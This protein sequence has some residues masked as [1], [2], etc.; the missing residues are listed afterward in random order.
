MALQGSLLGVL[1]CRTRH[2]I[3]S[4]QTHRCHPALRNPRETGQQSAGKL[5]D[6]RTRR[7]QPHGSECQWQSPMGNDLR[8]AGG[9]AGNRPEGAA[10][11]R[12]DLRAG[13]V[14]AHGPEDQ[15]DAAKA[16]DFPRSVGAARPQVGENAAACLLDVAHVWARKH[17]VQH[18]PNSTTAHHRGTKPHVA[19]RR[20]RPQDPE[21]EDLR[22]RQAPVHFQELQG[23]P[24]RLARLRGSWVRGLRHALGSDQSVEAPTAEGHVEEREVDPIGLLVQRLGYLVL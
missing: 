18:F 22:R 17:L 23:R 3:N 7:V 10:C 19:E 15:P 1:R 24:S 8:P 14:R 11:S 16:R 20:Q 4:T 13:R 21:A 12:L 9:A 2:G 5:L 6:L